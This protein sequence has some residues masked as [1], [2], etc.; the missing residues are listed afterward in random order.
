MKESVKSK[1]DSFGFRHY[2]IDGSVR[3][4]KVSSSEKE[5]KTDNVNS[6]ISKNKC[7]VR[8]GSRPQYYRK[9]PERAISFFHSNKKLFHTNDVDLDKAVIVDGC[10]DTNRV[11]LERTAIPEVEF[12]QCLELPNDLNMNVL[13]KCIKA[14]VRKLKIETLIPPKFEDSLNCKFN[15]KTK[16]GFTSEHILGHKT[17]LSA[18]NS[19]VLAAKSIWNDIERKSRNIHIEHSKTKDYDLSSVTKSFLKNDLPGKGVYDIGAR[20]KRDVDY[21]DNDL[22]TSRA[23]HMP[24]FHNEIVMAPWIDSIT[25][26]IKCKRKGPVYIGNS[27]S[28]FV[29]YERDIKSSKDF[30]EGDWKRFDS[31]LYARICITAISILRCYYPARSIRSDCFFTFIGE[32]IVLKDYYMPGGKILRMIHGLPSG[33]KCTNLLGSIINLLCLNFCIESRNVKNFSF[34]VG[35]DDFVIFCRDLID[36]CVI[37]DIKLRSKILGM[38]FKFLDRKDINS[39]NLNDLPYFYKYSVRNGEPVLKPADLLQRIFI[40]WNKSY[41]NTLKYFNFLE[42]QIPQLGYPSA[43]L[44]PFYSIYTNIYN[45]INIY[46]AR[47]TVGKIY[48]R[49]KTLFNKY[50]SKI[51]HKSLVFDT[52]T[53]FSFLSTNLDDDAIREANVLLCNPLYVDSHVVRFSGVSL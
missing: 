53:I 25:E 18:S 33:T 37:E 39:N 30:I 31:S 1:S 26:S 9:A 51:F 3:R 36:E 47:M 10:F 49:H 21:D 32:R 23:I 50:S 17:K 12:P 19:S 28:D 15:K 38:E 40:P 2:I 6:F 24:E 35:G 43:S 13:K 42:D 14:T 5:F 52:D 27:I 46:G 34:A 16:P 7:Q 4:V 20:A 48:D 22:A 8:I 45:S 11:I 44:L 29:R 41:N